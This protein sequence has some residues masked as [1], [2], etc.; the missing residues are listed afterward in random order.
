MQQSRFLEQERRLVEEKR[1]KYKGIAYIKLDIL[2]FQWNE[3]RE[4][5]LKNVERLKNCFRT[6]GCCRLELENYV[7]AIINQSQLDDAMRASTI[8]ASAI[9]TNQTDD[10][11]ELSFLARYQLKCL[12]RRY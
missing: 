6:E 9:M 11:P 4:P 3:L 10:Y 8:S 2:Y 5:N 12:H 1:I 7:P